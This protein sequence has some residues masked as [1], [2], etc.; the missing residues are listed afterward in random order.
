MNANLGSICL[1]V[2]AEKTALILPMLK[3]VNAIHALNNA[4]R[5][6]VFQSVKHAKVHWSY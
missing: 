6:K 3:A 4:K 2:L 1:L 5:V